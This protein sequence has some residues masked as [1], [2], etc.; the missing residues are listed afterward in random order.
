MP[1]GERRL[2]DQRFLQRVRRAFAFRPFPTRAADEQLA[3]LCRKHYFGMTAFGREL[4]DIR[5]RHGQVVQAR[6]PRCP[7]RPCESGSQQ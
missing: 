5:G 6:R 1:Y 2:L 7:G 4:A 3:A